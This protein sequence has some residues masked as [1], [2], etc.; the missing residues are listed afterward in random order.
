[1]STVKDHTRLSRLIAGSHGWAAAKAV[2]SYEMN[3]RDSAVLS[4]SA[5]DLLKIFPD[6]PGASAL[7]SAA[8]AV[9]LEGRLDAPVHEVAGALTVAGTVVY[10]DEAPFDVAKVL[11][12]SGWNGH[13]WVMVGDYIVDIAL[14]RTAYSAQQPTL[15]SRHVHQTFG[16]GKALYVDLWK[17][18]PRVGLLYDP[19]YVL[20]ADEVTELM[21]GAYHTIKQARSA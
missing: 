11:N 13:V 21:G 5:V 12:G 2:K 20:S 14:F 16:P 6:V 3:E 8:L 15:L 1:M 4:K 10:G 18:T 9:S 7:M 19:L 17:R